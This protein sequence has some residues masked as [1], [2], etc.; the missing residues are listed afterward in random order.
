MYPC[1]DRRDFILVGRTVSSSTPNRCLYEVKTLR[2]E[3]S[4]SEPIAYSDVMISIAHA[5][6][7]ILNSSIV[8]DILASSNASSISSK[9]SSISQGSTQHNPASV[10]DRKLLHSCR[11]KC[12]LYCSGLW[13]KYFF[14]ILSYFNK[15]PLFL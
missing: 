10:N 9:E 12:S 2:V 15:S 14:D 4:I 5:A 7:K 8:M 13:L 1:S 11:S 3:S 6:N